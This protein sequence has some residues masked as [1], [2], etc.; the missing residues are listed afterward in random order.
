MHKMQENISSKSNKAVG[1][2]R[3]E[4]NRYMHDDLSWKLLYKEF[5]NQS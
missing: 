4:M 1:L 5:Q 3:I 2:D